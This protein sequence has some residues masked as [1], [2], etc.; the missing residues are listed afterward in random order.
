MVVLNECG[1]CTVCCR[2]LPIKALG[3]K[4]HDRCEHLKPQGEGCRIYS[5]RPKVCQDFNCTWK[6]SGWVAKYR[7]D[8]LGMMFMSTDKI[9]GIETR[10]NVFVESK[11]V[12][13]LVSLLQ[14]QITVNIELYSNAFK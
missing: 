6:L 9:H 14:K 12:Q 5:K 3:K 7:P 11:E 10:P 13:N 2:V 1:D 4:A 8:K